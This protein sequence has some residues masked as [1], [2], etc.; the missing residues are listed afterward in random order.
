MASDQLATDTVAAP[1]KSSRNRWLLLIAAVVVLD[2]AALIAFPPF[3]SGGK[4]GDACPFP[5]CFIQGSL[6]FPAPHTV[7]DLDPAS[8][9]TAN[10]IVTF[11][12][13]ITSTLLTMWLVMAIVV[14]GSA[15]LVRGSKLV[16]G[17]GQNVIEFVYEFLERLRAGARRAHGEAIHPALRSASSC[18]SCSQLDRADPAG[19]QGRGAARADE[20]R[21]HHHR[22]GPGAF[23]YL[24]VR[25]L[26]PSRLPR[27]PR[28]VLPA[29]TSSERHRRGA[30]RDVRRD[31]RAHARVRQAGHAVD[32]TLRQH[33][34][35]RGRPRRH[36]R[37]DHRDPPDRAARR[38][39]CCS[40]RP[41]PD[42]QHPDPH[43]H[44]A[45]DR[46][47]RRRGGRHRGRSRRRRSRA[48][49]AVR[50]EPAAA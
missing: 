45:R 31:H 26:P 15:L 22:P 47:P 10:G 50:P 4:P 28:Q 30:H 40:T 27:L 6:E 3:P 36:H 11:H 19:R 5:A 17:R 2:I 20:R 18:S 48:I 21:E 39:R 1:R 49:A 46:E 38:S 7:I 43:V 24:R 12:P 8:A 44:R 34:R 41:G 32:A 29:L 16:P 42:L 37:A 35:R 23:V 13:A 25:G 33:L 14:I 9:A